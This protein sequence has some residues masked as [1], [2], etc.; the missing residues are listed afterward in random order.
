MDALSWDCLRCLPHVRG[1]VSY[2]TSIHSVPR[3]VFPTSVGVFPGRRRGCGR[4]F[5]LP[6]VR[7]GVS[8]VQPHGGADAQSSP[9]PWGCFPGFGCNGGARLVFPTSVGVFPRPAQALAVPRRL[10]HVRGGVSGEI[11]QVDPEV[12]SSPRPW[13]CFQPAVLQLQIVM[14]FPTS[15]GVFPKASVDK[16]LIERLPHVRGGVSMAVPD[17]RHKI[18]SSPR[19]W[20]CF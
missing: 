6:H 5:G 15:V 7:G 18:E 16:L 12:S 2:A 8:A 17:C 11:I 4:V 9:R 19:P 13:G 14:V 10:P 20:G 3:E 1:G